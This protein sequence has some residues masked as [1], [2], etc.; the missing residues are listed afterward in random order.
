MNCH[1]C[2]NKNHEDDLYCALCRRLTVIDQS[3]KHKP[4]QSELQTIPV[5]FD[6]TALVNGE[7]Q[8]KVFRKDVD[9]RT[10]RETIKQ[11]HE[12]IVLSQTNKFARV[13][14]PLAPNVGGDLNPE[15]SQ[16]FPISSPR[17]WIEIIGKQ[18]PPMSIP[19]TLR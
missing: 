2:N 11:I 18:D 5:S 10:R 9:E 16:Q 12:G 1:Y 19:A 15:V 13:Y 7:T 4:V 14:N 17:C 3:G 8:V 6:P